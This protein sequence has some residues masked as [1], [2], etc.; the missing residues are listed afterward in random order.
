MTW[1]AALAGLDQGGGKAVVLVADPEAPH[2]AALLRAV[3]RAVD[4]L[5]GRYL[6]AEDVGATTAD[7]DALGGGHALGHGRARDGRRVG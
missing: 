1:K 3:G 2:P 7:M 6:A 5:G 4:E